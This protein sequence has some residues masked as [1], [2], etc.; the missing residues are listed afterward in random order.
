[1]YRASSHY[2]S[3][4]PRNSRTRF[5]S[6]TSDSL[7]LHFPMAAKKKAAVATPTP[8]VPVAQAQAHAKGPSWSQAAN[9]QTV[10]SFLLIFGFLFL[11]R[12]PDY[13]F[14]AGQDAARHVQR[15]SA[16]RPEHPFLTPIT[17]DALATTWWQLAGVVVV[18]V[19]WGQWLK[20]QW[21]MMVTAQKTSGMQQALDK[22]N[23]GKNDL[24]VSGS[25]AG[26]TGSSWQSPGCCVRTRHCGHRIDTNLPAPDALRRTRQ[27]VSSQASANLCRVDRSRI[28]PVSTCIL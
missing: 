8:A 23:Q 22:Q 3:R 4:V 10:L 6:C 12:T 20:T 18:M 7:H 24:L 15:A 21:Q 16:D 28:T 5:R 1:M 17:N 2:E 25:S 19:W 27:I 26:R 11:P 14:G 13:L 9:K